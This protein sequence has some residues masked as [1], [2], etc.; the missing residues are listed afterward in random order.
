MFCGLLACTADDGGRAGEP[1]L[2]TGTT[3]GGVAGTSDGGTSGAEGDG[4]DDSTSGGLPGTSSG[5]GSTDEGTSTGVANDCP[6]VQIDVGPGS[7]LNVRPDPSTMND[8]VGSLAHGAI[9]DVL[10]ETIGEDVDGSSLW[11]EIASGPLE[12][13][14]SAT[15]A[16]CTSEEPPVIDEDGWYVPLPCGMTATI[17]QGNNGATS[18]TGNSAFAFDF[19]VALNTPL[20]AIASGTVAY[21]FDETGPDDPC[22]NGGDS[23]CASFANYAIVR[24]ADGTLS[25]YRHLNQVDVAVGDVIGVGETVGLSGS[26]GWATGRHAHVMRMEDCGAPFCQSI[27]LAF[28]DVAGDGVPVTGDDVTSGNCP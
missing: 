28:N 5:D 27:P 19:A 4:G 9:V 3:G 25:T 16:T 10:G 23:S 22:Y 1:L 20:V 24:H 2:G 26:T 11:F 18:H 14:V 8:P 17:S 15:F 6:R 12:G 21:T 13:F 7:T